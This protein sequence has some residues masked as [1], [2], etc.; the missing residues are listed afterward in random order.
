MDWDALGW[1]SLDVVWVHLG[2]AGRG[3]N[4]LNWIGFDWIA[5][6]WA[7]WGW[8]ASNRIG[9]DWIGLDWVGL[10]WIGLGWEKKRLETAR[11]G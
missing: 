3:R 7:G 1:V 8:I 5:L 4:E 6:G 2:F 11:T 9:L 10:D